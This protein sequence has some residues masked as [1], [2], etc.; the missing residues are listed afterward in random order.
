[1]TAQPQAEPR[2]LRLLL[3]EDRED[4]ALL[5]LA[6]LERLGFEVRVRR[7]QSAEEMASA[8]DG[9]WDLVVSDYCLPQFDALRALRLR[10]QRRPE[11]PFVIVSGTITEE[12]AVE[13]MR[14][15]AD[16]F[17]TKQR[18]ARLGPAI[19]RSLREHAERRARRAAEMRLRQA[20]KMEAIGQLAGGVAHDFNNLLGVIQGYGELVLKALPP[21]DRQRERM[22]HILHAAARG[23]SLTRQLLTFSR[24][25][26]ADAR[27]LELASAVASVEKLLRRLIGENIEVV[28]ATDG[29]GGRVRADPTHLEQI[30]MNL[31]INARDAMPSGGRLVIG[32][33]D[34]EST[35]GQAY[36]MHQAESVFYREA[37]FYS[38]DE[39]ARLL[40]ETGFSISAWGQTLAHPVPETREIEPLRPG[41]GQCAFVVVAAINQR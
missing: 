6:E 17:I 9:E 36:L 16:D 15:G 3:V 25:Q 7:V 23:A 14:Q 20:Q 35:L 29:R 21:G 2:S 40:L 10:N 24:Q 22:E 12:E 11:L 33:I 32:F 18:L 26:P 4:D 28:I 5:L 38:A 27:V 41:R 19:S 37:T 39:V 31:A 34:R 13:A 30:V 8:L 1:M